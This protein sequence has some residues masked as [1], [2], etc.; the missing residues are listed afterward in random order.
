MRP[1]C[2][3]G[4]REKK[5]TGMLSGC[6]YLYHMGGAPWDAQLHSFMVI[7]IIRL[8]RTQYQPQEEGCTTAKEKITCRLPSPAYRQSDTGCKYVGGL[9]TGNPVLQTASITFRS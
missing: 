8:P 1:E 4:L 6:L 7:S 3:Q 2:L 9:E 5:L